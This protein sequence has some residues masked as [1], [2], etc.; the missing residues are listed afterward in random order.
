MV[1]EDWLSKIHLIVD[2]ICF[3]GLIYIISWN[4]INFV[5]RMAT[6]QEVELFLN[7]LKD[8]IKVFEVA[9]RPR[10]KNLDD[11]AELDITPIKRLEYLMNLKAEDYYGGA[12][13]DTYDPTKPDYYEF[14]IQ[15]KGKEVYIKIS[16]GLP[17]KMV[18]CM[19]FH[20]AEFPMNYPLKTE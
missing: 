1:L 5:D 4:T 13:K 20:I 6:K 15:V 18:D 12:K 9:F 16:P 2:F 8:K 3:F 10:G 11:L 19:S 17:N 14:G 7:Q